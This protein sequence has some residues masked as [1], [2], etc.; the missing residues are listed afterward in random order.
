MDLVKR[1]EEY[2]DREREL[3]WEGTFAE[4]FEIATKKTEIVRLSQERIYH[5]IMDA[6]VETTRIGEPRYNFFSEEIFGIEKP[7]QQIVDYFHSAAQRLEVRKRVLL[8][9]GPVGGGKSTIVHLLKRGLEAYS[10]APAGAV[11]AIKSCPMHEEPL[12]LI[13]NDLRED[14]ERALVLYVECDLCPHS[15][16]MIDNQYR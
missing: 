15:R 3:Q 16:Y 12:H 14:V 13:P 9:M 1:L 5:M 2:R 8:L 6:G 7:L 10:R 11:Y 4:Y